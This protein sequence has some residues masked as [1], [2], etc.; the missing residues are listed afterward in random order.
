MSRLPVSAA[1]LVFL[2]SAA[3]ALMAAPTAQDFAARAAGS[4]AFQVRAGEIALAKAQSAAVKEHARRMVADHNALAAR[5]KAAV[6]AARERLAMPSRLDAEHRG[7]IARL[8][9]A[10]TN[11]FDALYAETQVETLEAMILLF[12]SYSGG[13][14]V[15]VRD[16]A[17]RTL[18]ML[19]AQYASAKRLR[20][21]L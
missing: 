12:H 2:A 5:L 3:L 16:F 18:P 11:G 21:R 20:S 13:P 7:R 4:A 17:H 15:P 9:R 1:A 10:S 6:G 8:E 14:V 19:E